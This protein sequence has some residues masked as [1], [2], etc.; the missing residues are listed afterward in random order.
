MT[1]IDG[2][3]MLLIQG[4]LSIYCQPPT[5]L[6]NIFLTPKLDF[7]SS[8]SIS[9]QDF[10]KWLQNNLGLRG[11]RVR[12]QVGSNRNLAQMIFDDSKT[13]ANNIRSQ[14]KA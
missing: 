12:Q 5:V 9:A 14:R 10:T 13:T 7:F 1:I 4:L 6:P 3:T 8:C 2:K 11:N